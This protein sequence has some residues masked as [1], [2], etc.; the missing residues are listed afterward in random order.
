[1]GPF[2]YFPLPTY[3]EIVYMNAKFS[4]TITENDS[5]YNISGNAYLEK[6]GET[7]SQVNGYGLMRISF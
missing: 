5:T 1:M 2:K 6:T 3:Y 4:G 7:N